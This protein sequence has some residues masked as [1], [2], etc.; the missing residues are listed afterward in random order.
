MTV[1]GALNS[2]TVIASRIR[3]S[4]NVIASEAKQ[5]IFFARQDG[6]LRRKR[7]SQ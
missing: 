3:N 2:Q 5:S 4:I 6:L 7:S 1:V